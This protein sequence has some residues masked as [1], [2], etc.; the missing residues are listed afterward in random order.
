MLGDVIKKA[1]VEKGITQKQISESL[2]INSRTYQSYES[3]EITP[4]PNKLILLALK[5]GVKPEFLI[6][7]SFRD[8]F[9]KILNDYSIIMPFEFDDIHITFSKKG[10][11]RISQER[12]LEL[13]E[14]ALLDYV[15]EAETFISK[16]KVIRE[17]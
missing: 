15:D 17:S 7:C 10:E 8:S 2:E 12:K 11:T 1:R 6:E 3:G 14:E 4:P 16:I 13:Y 9:H 5:L